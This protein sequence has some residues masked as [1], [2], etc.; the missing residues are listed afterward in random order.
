MDTVKRERLLR[1]AVIIAGLTVLY[2]IAGKLGLRLAYFHASASAVW[3]P[4][5]IAIAAL[6]ILGNDVWPAVFLGAFLVNLTTAGTV[7]TSIGIAAG[8]TG[9]ALA[10]TYLVRRFA[11][12]RHPFERPRNVLLF[13]ILA[14]LVSTT[15]AASA[16]TT[17]L[18]LGGFVRAAQYGTVWLTWWLGD[19]A[20]ALLVAPALLLWAA[21]HRLRWSPARSM[22]AV[23]LTLT[24]LVVGTIV[25]AALPFFD[26]RAYPLSFLALPPL[27]WA[28][29]RFGSRET[30]TGTL[31]LGA[32]AIRG[33]IHGAGSF[34]VVDRNT[35]LLLLQSFLMVTSVTGLILAAV[36]AERRRAEG[37]LRQMAV[38]DPLTGLTNFRQLAVVLESEIQRSR[39]N[40]RPFT[41]LFFDM[42]LLKRINDR[43][44]HLVGSRAL[45]R[46]A[47]AIQ[48]T[49]RAVDT[50]ARY[51][52]DEFAV[53]LPET[54]ED[55]AR[56]VAARVLERL[57]EDVERPRLSASVGVAQYPRDGETAEELIGAADRLL[58]QA[59]AS[60]EFVS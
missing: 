28:A 20:G 39:R 2:L 48:Y 5:G 25:F 57:R 9:E 41:V 11:R 56:Q 3:P 1:Q 52:G 33:T 17:S 15:L 4:T 27:L 54:Q 60:R 19:A 49:C 59:K 58:Y 8:N 38:S 13:S 30:A 7:L 44:G 46:L 6:L 45:V 55:D 47:E 23:T 22:E 35:S 40:G 12:G 16:G 51:G 36:V 53:V 37:W 24:L 43:H 50:A 18:Y 10:A 14:G 26:N 21:D 29:L 34:G 32:V 42:D 31:L